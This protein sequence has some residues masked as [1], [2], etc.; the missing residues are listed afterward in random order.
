MHSNTLP[1][2]FPL[3]C[4]IIT[5]IIRIITVN[6]T[7]KLNHN[8]ATCCHWHNYSALLLLYHLKPLH[9]HEKT[10]TFATKERK[11]KRN[12]KSRGR[13]EECLIIW[14]HTPLRFEWTEQLGGGGGGGAS[15]LLCACVFVPEK[16]GE[17][18][19][20]PGK[21]NVN[22]LWSPHNLYLVLW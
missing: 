20:M 13:E 19:G 21:S 3:L 5:I 1:D 2:L 7:Y 16:T 11:N 8:H 22:S 6:E 4:L 14:H 12:L 15:L 17:L 10:R 9:H 18:T